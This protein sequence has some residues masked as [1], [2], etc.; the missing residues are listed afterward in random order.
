M[1]NNDRT[2]ISDTTI[3]DSITYTHTFP[4]ARP[5]EQPPDIIECKPTVP[6]LKGILRKNHEVFADTSLINDVWCN[7]H[8]VKR[9]KLVDVLDTVN[10]PIRTTQ[11]QRDAAWETFINIPGSIFKHQGCLFSQHVHHRRGIPV[12]CD[13]ELQ[14]SLNRTQT[15]VVNK[16]ILVR[17]LRECPEKL[18]VE[19]PMRKFIEAIDKHIDYNYLHNIIDRSRGKHVYQEGY[20]CLTQYPIKHNIVRVNQV[21]GHVQFADIC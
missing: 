3:E 9:I 7:D 16:L 15:Q 13:T 12:E 20:N 10:K 18:L 17:S 11:R 1:S 21:T 4:F 2:I 19:L 6:K 8:P 14:W 5:S